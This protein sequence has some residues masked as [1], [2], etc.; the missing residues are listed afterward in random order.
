VTAFLYRASGRETSV[1]DP[2]RFLLRWRERGGLGPA[3]ESIREALSASVPS[4]SPAIRP[5]LTGAT[6]PTE[7]RRGLERALD[8]AIGG[9]ESLEPPASRWWSVIGFL[10]TIATVGLALSAA[11]VVVWILARP[12]TGSVDLPVV[13]PVPSP[14]VS[15]VAFLFAGYVLARLLGAHAGW[16]GSRWADRV[17]SR[18][19]GAVESEIREHALEPLDRLEDA[20]RRLWTAAGAIEDTCGSAGRR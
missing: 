19:A 13:G 5:V 2:K 15:L 10:Q 12:L 11:W 20:R 14:F 18:V 17:R 7:V 6:E 16:V 8:R 1:A 9:V 3:V 4:A